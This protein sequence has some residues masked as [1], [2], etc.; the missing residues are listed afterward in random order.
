MSNI[1]LDDLQEVHMAGREPA[2][3]AADPRSN[4]TSKR[5]AP[6]VLLEK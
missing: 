2:K 1:A 4:V 3:L 5:R 6:N